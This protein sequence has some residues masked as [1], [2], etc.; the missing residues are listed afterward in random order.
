LNF[1]ESRV[2]IFAPPLTNPVSITS[3]FLGEKTVEYF[4]GVKSVRVSNKNIK[5]TQVGFV[6]GGSKTMTSIGE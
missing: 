3:S 1:D 5:A 4:V 2:L 6:V